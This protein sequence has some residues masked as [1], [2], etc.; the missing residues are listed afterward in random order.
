MRKSLRSRNGHL[1]LFVRFLHG[2]S[3]E[4]NQRLPGGLLGRTDN[5][6]ETIQRLL[7]GL[8]GR[9]DNRPETIQRAIKNLKEMSSD[10]ISPDRSINIFHCLTEMKDHSVHQEITEF[11]KSENRSGKRLSEIHCSALADM[12]QMSEEV[13]RK[14]NTSDEGRRTERK[15]EAEMFVC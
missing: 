6:P 4:S 1:D 13:L 9:T 7:G 2:L 12:L 3:L 15:S 10:E 5:R 11:L 14:Y 8:L